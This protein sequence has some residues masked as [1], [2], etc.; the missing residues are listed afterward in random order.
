MTQTIDFLPLRYQEAVVQRRSKAWR[1]VVIC[2]FGALLCLGAAGQHKLRHNV[3]AESAAVHDQ[4]QV[5]QA[6]SMRLD[7]LDHSLAAL[8]ARADLLTYLR[9]PWPRTQILAGILRPLPETISLRRVRIAR[10]SRT[11]SPTV[12]QSDAASAADKLAPDVADLERMRRLSDAERTVAMIEGISTD[13]T[14]L[15]RFLA[16]LADESLFERAELVS[17][18]T[19]G[20][21]RT[22]SQAQ[23][24]ARVVV[25]P[26]YGQPGGPTTST[27]PLA[28]VSSMAPTEIRP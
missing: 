9:H 12:I 20:H 8:R 2:A 16:A 7:S 11:A 27:R 23:F 15:H 19:S 22:S 5:V 4:F 1:L 14:E 18:E 28:D 26:G 21:D 17:M 25:R 3:E 10:E 13:D 24:T 6:R